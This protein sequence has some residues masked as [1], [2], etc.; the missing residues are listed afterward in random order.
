M[1]TGSQVRNAVYEIRTQGEGGGYAPPQSVEVEVGAEIRVVMY[2]AVGIGVSGY[3]V[4]A[5][6]SVSHVGEVSVAEIVDGKLQIGAA[7][8]DVLLRANSIGAGTAKIQGI[9]G[10]GGTTNLNIEV[11]SGPEA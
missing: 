1:S 10:G 8:T 4:D 5:G 3:K 6:G 2:S 11:T 9:G 7:R